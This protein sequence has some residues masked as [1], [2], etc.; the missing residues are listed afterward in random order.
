MEDMDNNT[1]SYKILFPP[2]VRDGKY[3]TLDGSKEINK[4]IYYSKMIIRNQIS[5]SK[6][7]IDFLNN[8]VYF[9]THNNG[10]RA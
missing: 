2:L 9:Y 3:F 5:L 10:K 4:C 8:A 6:A 1:G 7:E